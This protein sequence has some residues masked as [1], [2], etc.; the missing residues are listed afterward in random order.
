MDIKKLNESLEEIRKN[1]SEAM[2]P[3]DKIKKN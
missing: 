2:S 1:L 3:E